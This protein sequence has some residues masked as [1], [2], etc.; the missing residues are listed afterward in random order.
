MQTSNN[1]NIL[2]KLFNNDTRS[3]IINFFLKETDIDVKAL[4][5]EKNKE[6]ITP[7]DKLLLEDDWKKD[8]DLWR[9]QSE[10]LPQIAKKIINHLK[11]DFPFEAMV[12][13][14][15]SIDLI[16]DLFPEEEEF[17]DYYKEALKNKL[18][19][20]LPEK[21]MPQTKKIKI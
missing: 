8:W 5:Q 3:P 16:K 6:G 12:N 18:V 1:E 13:K 17:F 7:L 21:N 15:K 2:H 14:Q 19:L 10:K 20:Q 9:R 11:A 4:L